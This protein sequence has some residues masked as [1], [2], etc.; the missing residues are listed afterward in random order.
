[1]SLVSTKPRTPARPGPGATPPAVLRALD[2][3]V[4]RRVESL[5]PG[6]HAT[7]A[8][9]AGVELAQVRPY[10]P[11]DDVRMMDWNVTARTREPHVRV[12]VAERALSTWLVLDT[13][14]SMAF[15]T[16]ERRK[17]DVAEG[18]A[19]AVGH[20]ASRRGN[21]LGV[22]TFGNRRPRALPPRQGRRGLL[23]LLQALREEPELD[24]TGFEPTSLGQAL[25][26]ADTLAR[27][28]GVIVAVSDFRGPRRDWRRPIMRLRGRHTVLAIEVRDR[29]EE[30]LP[31]VGEL[32]LVDPES[33][34]QL[35]VDTSRRQI[36]ER[37]AGEAAREREELAR[38]L[39]AAGAEHL[40]LRTEGDWL[41]DLARFL[42]GPGGR[43]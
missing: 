42:A 40:V 14:P 39:R 32:W 9:G 23:G 30:E 26:R 5:I 21:R 7:P 1:V 8:V 13:S 24:G 3:S 19:L 38:E 43:R 33:G 28:R 2:L 10:Q 36:R 6:D 17:Y 34:R 22:L 15:G 11:G 16:Q 27:Q 4:R 31:P 25:G 37:F 20:I 41:R 35:R 12:H 18:V 29:R